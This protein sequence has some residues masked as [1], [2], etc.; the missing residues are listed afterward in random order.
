MLS[1][2]LQGLW[3]E[4]RGRGTH[5]IY[6]AHPA[7]AGYNA[8]SQAMRSG[9]RVHARALGP[10]LINGFALERASRLASKSKAIYLLVV[11]RFA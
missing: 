6:E 8:S 7:G 10:L 11:F 2:S 9:L 5:H 4:S 1:D 3:I